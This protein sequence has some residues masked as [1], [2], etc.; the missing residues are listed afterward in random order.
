MRKPKIK[1]KAVSCYFGKKLEKLKRKEKGITVLSLPGP[2]SALAPSLFSSWL[3]SS[4]ALC[5]RPTSPSLSLLDSVC[6]MA[7]HHSLSQEKG[8]S[9]QSPQF[10]PVSR[11]ERNLLA[12]KSS[13]R[14][15]ACR[16]APGSAVPSKVAS[17][18]GSSP[19]QPLESEQVWGLLWPVSHPQ[20][21]GV[22]WE[23]L[24]LQGRSL[25]R[26][27]SQG[28]GI[29]W[30]TALCSFKALTFQNCLVIFT[31][32]LACKGTK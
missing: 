31:G 14:L 18:P 3:T 29:S 13:P 27:Q 26:R 10:R 6:A 9:F 24:E 4:W 11:E 22:P 1:K 15:L 8:R 7:Q 32:L 20:G 2:S 5:F 28:G 23:G 19:G 12:S 21:W 25:W 17:A 30:G 16:L